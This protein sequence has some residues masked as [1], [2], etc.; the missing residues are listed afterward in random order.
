MKIR[1]LPGLVLSMLLFSLLVGCAPAAAPSLSIE[2]A[3][4][5]PSP[6][7]PTAGGMYMLIKNVGTAPD[8]LLSGKSPACG[9]I[10]V[11]KMVMKSDGTQGMDLVDKPLEIP[12]GGQLE[13]KPGDLHIMCIMKKDDQFTIGAKI[14]L[15]LVFEKS[16][17]KTVSA[18][19]R[20]Q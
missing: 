16:G 19:I 20:S 8:K 15:T 12:A 3:W 18:E 1:L 9:S 17:E 7:M 11:H 10:E 4:G 2:N 5:R 14:D 13:L 6:T